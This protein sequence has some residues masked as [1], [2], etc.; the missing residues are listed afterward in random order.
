VKEGEARLGLL[1]ARGRGTEEQDATEQKAEELKRGPLHCVEPPL[2]CRSLCAA[3]VFTDG[4]GQ[5]WASR[6]GDPRLRCHRPGRSQ[7]WHEEATRHRFPS[8]QISVARMRIRR[9]TRDRCRGSNCRHRNR[10][11]S[12]QISLEMPR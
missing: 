8:S 12:F 11:L 2:V 10:L 5:P 6:R 1:S 9:R 7:R 4:S 3:L